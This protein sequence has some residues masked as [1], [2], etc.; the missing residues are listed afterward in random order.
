MNEKL[1]GAIYGLAVGDALG[2]P[3]EFRKR[4]TFR[5]RG[6]DGYGT[7]NQ[8]AGTWSDDTSLTL[9]TLESIK[10]LERIDLDDIMLNFVKWY[11]YAAF[12]AHGRVFDVGGTTAAAIARY[13]SGMDALNCGIN[14]R[15]ANGNGSLMRILPLAFVPHRQGD[16]YQV[17]ALTHAHRISMSACEIYVSI[18]EALMNGQTVEDAL[19]TNRAIITPFYRLQNAGELERGEI[20][21]TGYV[22]DTLEAALW[23]LL[24]TKSYKECVLEAVN[25]GDDTD[26]VVAVAGGLAGI[27]YGYDAIPDKWIKKLANKE[28]IDSCFVVRKNYKSQISHEHLEQIEQ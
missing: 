24:N 14:D 20:R 8:P 21:S 16:I 4:G 2:V 25:L 12:T 22:V 19:F 15:Y 28:L 6:M 5:C 7:H 3:Y 26:T 11:E 17:S 23:C 13:R 10:R 27:L 1:K 18:A 9:A